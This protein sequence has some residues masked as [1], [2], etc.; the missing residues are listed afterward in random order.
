MDDKNKQFNTIMNRIVLGFAI[1]GFLVFLVLVPGLLPFIGVV[2]IISLVI[3]ILTNN[4]KENDT[5]STKE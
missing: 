2:T 5:E 3:M 1:F 4:K